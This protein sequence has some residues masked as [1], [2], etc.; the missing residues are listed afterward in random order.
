M[1]SLMPEVTR[2]NLNHSI[3]ARTVIGLFKENI[4]KQ[5]LQGNTGLSRQIYSSV[6]AGD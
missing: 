6:G 5:T 2:K 4:S 1:A 3:G